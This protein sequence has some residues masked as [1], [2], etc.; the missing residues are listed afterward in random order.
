VSI[1]ESD[2]PVVPRTPAARRRWFSRVTPPTITLPGLSDTI[3]Q[4]MVVKK[5]KG[6]LIGPE[7]FSLFSAKPRKEDRADGIHRFRV[8]DYLS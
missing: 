7:D 2:A 4:K 6:Q 3:Y 1:L 8:S 5:Y